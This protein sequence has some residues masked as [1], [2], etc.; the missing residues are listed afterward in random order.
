MNRFR[1]FFLR[2]FAAYYWAAYSLHHKLFLKPGKKLMHSRLMVVGSFRVGGAGKTP[3]TL[4]LAR[5]LIARGKRVAILCHKSAFDEI[6]LYQ[7]E[8]A[9]QIQTGAAEVTGT[10]NRYRTAWELDRRGGKPERTG[11]AGT[12]PDFILCDDGFEDSR[13]RP[14]AVFRLDWEK[15]PTDIHQLIPAGKFR[16]LLQDHARDLSKTIA[17]RCYGV[18]PDILFL[19]DSI[20]NC[21]GEFPQHRQTIVLCGLGDP[22]RFVHDLRRAELNPTKWIFRPD[23][24]KN[25][26]KITR[27]ILREYPQADLVLS[28]KDGLRL[29]RT[30]LENPRIFVARQ[31]VQVYEGARAQIQAVLAN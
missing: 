24:D 23:H 14:H 20:S 17:L 2:I 15:A 30:L 10:D 13:L 4:W 8:L 6:R 5:Y 9:D 19:I 27:G 22:Q 12:A 16:S 3:F 25:F 29:S 26:E 21:K 7:Q 18:K 31:S 28:Q 11:S 1:T